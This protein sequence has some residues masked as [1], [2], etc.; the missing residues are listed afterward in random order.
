[1]KRVKKAWQYVVLALLALLIAICAAMIANRV[2]TDAVGHEILS[3]Y[4]AYQ[5]PRNQSTTMKED[6]RSS[7]GSVRATGGATALAVD[8]K[9]GTSPL[10]AKLLW[11]FQKSCGIV[12]ACSTEEGGTP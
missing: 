12:C 6:S 4:A 10:T 5:Q 3:Q 9:T 8:D 1:M 7:N 11:I 2:V